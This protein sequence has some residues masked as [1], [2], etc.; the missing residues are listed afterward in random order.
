MLLIGG[1]A[2]SEVVKYLIKN[3]LADVNVK[4]GHGW[5]CLH[6]ATAS[7]SVEK[8]TYLMDTVQLKLTD[9]DDYFKSPFDVAVGA[10]LMY[11]QER[12]AK[13]FVTRSIAEKNKARLEQ[14]NQN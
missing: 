3:A 6:F 5:S 11:L 10:C 7:G 1:P 2:A 14:N 12:K 4:S 13:G 9:K 8:A